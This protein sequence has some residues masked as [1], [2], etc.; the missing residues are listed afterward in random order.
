MRNRISSILAADKITPV[1][2][3]FDFLGERYS[4]TR[5]TSES[6]VHANSSI[7]KI[8]SHRKR[9]AMNEYNH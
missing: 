4:A 8:L 2:N 9:L 5:V 3:C 6:P 1:V 7:R